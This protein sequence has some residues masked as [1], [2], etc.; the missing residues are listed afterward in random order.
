MTVRKADIAW[1]IASIAM[2]LFFVTACFLSFSNII[3]IRKCE[4]CY[5]TELVKAFHPEGTSAT[6]MLCDDCT[7]LA[8]LSEIIE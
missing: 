5:Q 3:A 4:T 8:K 7:K 1:F 2:A 6:L